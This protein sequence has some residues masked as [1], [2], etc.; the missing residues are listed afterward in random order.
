MLYA[1]LA[2]HEK[3]IDG[4]DQIFC[5]RKLGAMTVATCPF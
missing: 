5:D 3:R 2:L 4:L 1:E